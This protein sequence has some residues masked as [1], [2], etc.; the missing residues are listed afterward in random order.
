MAQQ[1]RG[2]VRP[3]HAHVYNTLGLSGIVAV[4]THYLYVI[5]E[6][7]SEKRLYIVSFEQPL[8][9]NIKIINENLQRFHA[10]LRLVLFGRC[11]CLVCGCANQFILKGSDYH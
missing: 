10:M 7:N 4:T 11:M 6:Y 8:T 2:G 5:I 3:L 9:T 1:I